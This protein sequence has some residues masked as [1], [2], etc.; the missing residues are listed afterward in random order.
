MAGLGLVG[1]GLLSVPLA[2]PMG[3]AA[4]AVNGLVVALGG[5]LLWFLVRRGRAQLEGA[6]AEREARLAQHAELAAAERQAML[7]SLAAGVAHQINNPLSAVV[8]NLGFVQEELGRVTPVLPAGGPEDLLAATE[9]ALE[10]AGRVSRIVRDLM[11]FAQP[12]RPEAPVD[13]ERILDLSVEMAG[14]ATR[15]RARVVKEYGGVPPAR[16]DASRLGE[17]FLHLIVNAAQAIPPGQPEASEIRLGTRVEQG[18]I[19]VSIR[20]TGTGM[21]SQVLQRA[22]EPFFTTR[23]VGSGVGLGLSTSR[24]AVRS[25]GGDIV[26]ESEPGRG[27]VFTVSLLLAR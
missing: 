17:V 16:G 21:T 18:R 7:G 13:V 10:G 25:L 11:A 15:H 3:E 12:D 24:A 23:P 2:R 14:P 22:F 4:A 5:A 26:A 19:L 1:Y 6:L 9:E 20:D 8:N 27:S